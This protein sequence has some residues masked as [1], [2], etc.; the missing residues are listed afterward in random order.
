MIVGFSCALAS[1]R[2][3]AADQ[4]DEFASIHLSF[5]RYLRPHRAV[6]THSTSGEVWSRFEHDDL[7]SSCSCSIGID[8]SPRF[9]RLKRARY[10]AKSLGPYGAISCAVRNLSDGGA[11]FEM[12]SPVGRSAEGRIEMR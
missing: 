12:K 3:S 8:Y 1:R 4:H 6:K 2:R 10:H 9:V 11:S 5:A 7:N